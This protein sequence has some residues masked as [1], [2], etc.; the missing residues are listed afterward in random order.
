V[1]ELRERDEG[2]VGQAVQSVLERLIVVYN[3]V[4][5][6]GPEPGCYLEGHRGH[7]HSVGLFKDVDI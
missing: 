1:G 4:G 3:Y 6:L 2:S 7:S 5:V